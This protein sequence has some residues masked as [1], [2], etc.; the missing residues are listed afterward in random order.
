MHLTLRHFELVE[1][2]C[3]FGTISRT[4]TA[5]G[6]TQPAVSRALKLLEQQIGGSLFEVSPRGLIPTPLAQIFIRRYA[7]L[8]Q[9]IDE[10][11]ADIET[12]K[13]NRHGRIVMGVGIYG[14]ILSA[15]PAVAKLHSRQPGL[16]FDLIERD[17]RDVTLGIMSHDIDI[18]LIDVEVAERSSE[19]AFEPLPKHPCSVVVRADHPLAQADHVTVTDL[20]RFP[21]CGPHPSS[22][23]AERSGE[24]AELFGARSKT[25]TSYTFAVPLA[26]HS[27]G[28][29][30]RIILE[31]DAF[32]IIPSIILS[33]EVSL[34]A[35]GQ[36]L[37][38]LVSLDIPDLYWLR[39]NYGLVWQRHKT[40]HP[41]LREL[42]AL[43]KEREATISAR[44]QEL[45]PERIAASR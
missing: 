27:L 45:F 12:L 11:V 26:V 14:S 40:L 23:A 5:M 1:A 30:R 41:S 36:T 35:P 38:R 28:A 6:L 43:V 20:K 9:P 21:Y 44:E 37:K 31:S 42:I 13:A 10:I 8:S 15:F 34:E 19:F 18:G 16:S 3:H 2:L 17:W 32:G 33:G 22:W 24:H 4:A 29:V 25:Q 7:Q 39:T